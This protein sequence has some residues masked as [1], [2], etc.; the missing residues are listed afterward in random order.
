MKTPALFLFIC[1]LALP[2]LV[3]GKTPWR[4]GNSNSVYGGPAVK[5]FKVEDKTRVLVGG[6][7][8]WISRHHLAFG[9]EGYLSV[10]KVE[11]EHQGMYSSNIPN[12]DF[13]KMGYG[14]L[15][16]EYIYDLSKRLRCSIEIHGG[17]GLLR[18]TT[19]LQ[20][21]GAVVWERRDSFTIIEPGVNFMARISR[22]VW[23]NI[24]GSYRFI[25]GLDSASKWNPYWIDNSKMSAFVATVALRVGKM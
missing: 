4:E 21:N 25:R 23:L 9:P 13:M 19:E 14:G 7:I 12:D 20:R 1:A 18:I 15:V 3:Q 24:G 16:A 2:A 17:T 11:I 10:K 6:R 8:C 22:Y 5:I